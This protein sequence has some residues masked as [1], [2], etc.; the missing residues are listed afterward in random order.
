MCSG[1]G[2]VGRV[3][4]M[5]VSESMWAA[6]GI[7]AA[8]GR[9]VGGVASIAIATWGMLG[10]TAGGTRGAAGVAGGAPTIALACGSVES[11]AAT[12]GVAPRA[13]GGRGAAARLGDAFCGCADRLL[14]R[15]MLVS[16][17]I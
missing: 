10:A 5:S 1:K 11:S 13:G 3:L 14:S 17:G 15:G 12:G 4:A 7:G 8:A 16:G 2:A 6:A 9:G